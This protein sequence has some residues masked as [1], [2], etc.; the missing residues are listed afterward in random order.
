MENSKMMQYQGLTDADRFSIRAQHTLE[1]E[2]NL[3]RYQLQEEEEPGGSKQ[4]T[5]H[6][7]DLLSRIERQ[8]AILAEAVNAEHVPESPEHVAGDPAE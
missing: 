5:A 2:V 7:A 3:F 4:R 6:I 1:L 8:R